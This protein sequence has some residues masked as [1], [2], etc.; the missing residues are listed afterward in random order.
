MAE[1]DS[2]SNGAA[3]DLLERVVL[4]AVGAAALTAERADALAEELAERGTLRRDEA[5]A[6]IEEYST[7]W[8]GDATRLGERAG[9][10]L[11][12][13]F[14]EL[15]LVTKD[16]VEELELR[17]AQLEHRLRLLEERPAERTPPPH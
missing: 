1:P 14:S 7:R 10:T 12:R 9:T 5:R 11:D 4:A 6:L 16:D 13:L 17:L 15:G 8:R 2:N 3:R